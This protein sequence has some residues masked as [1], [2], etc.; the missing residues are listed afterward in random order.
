M[1]PALRKRDYQPGARGPLAGVRVLDL[2]RL[3]AGN[4]LTQVLGD[5]GAEVIKVEPPAGDTLRAWQTS[6]V[7]T[8]WKIYARSDRHYVKKFEEE[9][10][11]EC[12]VLLDV[13]ASMA[14]RGSA[15]MSKLEYGSVLAGA[16]A[17]LMHR[18]RDATGLMAFDDRIT[19]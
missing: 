9:T 6:G 16:L 14:Y 4:M 13:S 17:F 18:Q 2:S 11:L 5:F 19:R 7:Q 1:S 10:N 3:V 8:N 15:P 12:H